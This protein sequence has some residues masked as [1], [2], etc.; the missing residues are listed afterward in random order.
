M[1][2][3]DVSCDAEPPMGSILHLKQVPA[4]GGDTLFREHV[5]GA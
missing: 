2:H 4:N 1:W 5:R 3:S